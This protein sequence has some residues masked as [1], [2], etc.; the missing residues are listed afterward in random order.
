MQT[1]VARQETVPWLAVGAR[2]VT[3]SVSPSTSV[4]LPSTFTWPA[5]F[6]GVV[7]VLSTAFGSSFTGVTVTETVAVSVPPWPSDTV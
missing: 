7:R 5:V 1:P 2:V 6:N 3:P 4:S